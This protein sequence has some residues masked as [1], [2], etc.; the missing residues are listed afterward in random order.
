MCGK[1][2]RPWSNAAFC[3]VWSGSTLFAHIYTDCLL[4]SRSV[5]SD[6]GLHCLR[7]STQIVCS[8]LAFC[9]V[10]SGS[11][12]FAHIC[13]SCLLRSRVL[14]R[15]IW[16]YTVCAHLHRLFAQIS[17][18]VASGLGLHFLRISVQ[19]VCSDL[20]FCGVWSGSTLFAEICLSEYRYQWRSQ[21]GI[22]CT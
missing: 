9:G 19:V 20:A 18:F 8:D 17:R 11:T 10:W 22:I 5:A 3:G 14:R 15:L 2:C 21:N 12:L 6:L 1:Q 16:G 13:P 4:R 7:I